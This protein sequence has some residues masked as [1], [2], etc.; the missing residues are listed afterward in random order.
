MNLAAKVLLKAPIL[1][2]SSGLLVDQWWSSVAVGELAHS[3]P[4][5]GHRLG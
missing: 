5:E 2:L 4:L 1:G 3:F